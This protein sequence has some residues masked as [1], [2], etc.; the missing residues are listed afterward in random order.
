MPSP[1]RSEAW[2]FEEHAVIPVRAPETGIYGKYR[3]RMAWCNLSIVDFQSR[4]ERLEELRKA[5][6]RMDLS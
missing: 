3:G 5:L 1:C 4:R 6:D 2:S